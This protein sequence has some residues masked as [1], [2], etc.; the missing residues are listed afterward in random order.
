[1]GPAGIEY[2]YPLLDRR[3]LGFPLGLSPHSATERFDVISMLPRS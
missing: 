3:V 1:M 2:R